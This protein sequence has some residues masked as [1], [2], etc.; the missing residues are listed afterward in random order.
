VASVDTVSFSASYV[1]PLALLNLL[2]VAC[3]E[4][5]RART[6]ELMKKAAEEQSHG[7]RWYEV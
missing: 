7:F 1:A 5:R 4:A 6:L 2:L 3:A